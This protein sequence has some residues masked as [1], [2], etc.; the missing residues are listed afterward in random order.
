MRNDWLERIEEARTPETRM[1]RIEEWVDQRHDDLGLDY[2]PPVYVAPW[3][4]FLWGTLLV[5]VWAAIIA[6]II[7]G[8]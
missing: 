2:E 7:F 6:G 1:A 3:K 4:R 8:G 5:V